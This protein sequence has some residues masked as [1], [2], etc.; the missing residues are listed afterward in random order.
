M[1][2]YITGDIHGQLPRFPDIVEPNSNIIILGDCGFNYYGENSKR[3]LMLKQQAEQTGFTFYCVRGNHEFRPQHLSSI[4]LEFDESVQGEVY[5]EPAFPHI[6]YFKD[7]GI[8]SIGEKKIGVIGGA[9]SIDKDLRIIQGWQWF[10]DEQLN[11]EERENCFKEF[12]DK[13][14]DLILSHTCPL[15]WQPTDLFLPCVDQSKVDNSMEIFLEEIA[16]SISWKAW[17]WGHYHRNRFYKDIKDKRKIMLF[18]MF[19]PLEEIV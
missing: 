5:Y 6:K 9:Y 2:W 18:D 11:E 10:E 4:V 15:S 14:I 19:E 13:E 8:Y 12:Q 16:N 1:N 17:C 3:D 7:F